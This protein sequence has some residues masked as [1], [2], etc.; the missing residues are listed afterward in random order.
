V[1]RAKHPANATF[2]NLRDDVRRPEFR[3]D[4]QHALFVK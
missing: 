2:A 4:G 1:S 3:S